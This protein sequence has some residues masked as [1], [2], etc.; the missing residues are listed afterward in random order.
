MKNEILVNSSCP[1]TRTMASIGTKWKPI[2]IYVLGK[3]KCRFGQLVVKIPI[4][5]RKILSQQL[6]ELEEDGII[7]RMAYNE[8]P[9]RVDYSL[10][11]KGLALL[12]ILRQLCKWENNWSD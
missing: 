12:P 11:G 2:I 1:V 9:P 7:I 3:N 5:S 10:S 4:I 6:K 8:I